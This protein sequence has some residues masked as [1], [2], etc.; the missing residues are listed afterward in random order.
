MS[1][2]TDTELIARIEKI[3]A[4]NR[5]PLG[6]AD[7]VLVARRNAQAY[8]TILAALRTRGVGKA[9]AD[10]WVRG[11]EFQ[12]DIATYWVLVDLF[13]AGA[14]HD[15]S[16]WVERYNRTGE[17]AIVELLDIAGVTLGSASTGFSFTPIDIEAVND[18]LA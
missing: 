17:L 1:F 13:A 3:A 10:L 4:D 18:A 11:A 5:E 6:V 7:H 8:D 16:D 14:P 12:L 2:A 15:K 9:Q